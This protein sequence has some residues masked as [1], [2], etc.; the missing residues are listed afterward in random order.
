MARAFEI[1]VTPAV[2]G[3][4]GFGLDA[5]AGTVP[6]FTIGAVIWAT[7]AVFVRLW[8]GYDLEMR[9]HEERFGT[10]RRGATGA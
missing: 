9:R 8:F 5:W 10:T 3:A 1:A 4:I 6:W 2:A 7:V